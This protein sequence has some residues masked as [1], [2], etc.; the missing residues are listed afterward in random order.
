[1]FNIY[2]HFK[3]NKELQYGK[4]GGDTGYIGHWTGVFLPSIRESLFSVMGHNIGHWTGVFLPSI[5]ES[6]CLPDLGGATAK[7][8]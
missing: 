8:E 3:I 5:R 4:E 1:M 7:P 2:N 6:L